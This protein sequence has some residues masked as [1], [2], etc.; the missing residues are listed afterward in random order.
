MIPSIVAH[1]LRDCVSDYL[2]TTFRGTS[3]GFDT[4]MERFIAQ[5]DNVGRGPYVSVGLPFRSGA[6]G[7]N[8]FP[9]IP[10][11]FSPHLHQE[12][13]FN[14][15]SPP[16]YQSTIVATGTG[17]GKTECFLLPLLEHCRQEAGKQGIKAIL[18]YPMNALA[19]DQAKRIAQLIDRT[20]SLKGRVTAGLYI[21]GE[22]DRP[23]A[24][25]SPEQVITDKSILRRSPPDI[26]L[27]NYKMLDY[28]LIQPETQGLWAFNQPETFRYLV[29]DEFHTFDG[30]QGT[31]LA[32]LVR[33]LKYRLQTPKQH[34]ACVG[35]SATL[36]GRESQTQMLAYAGQI[37]Q[38]SFDDLA[39][40]QEDR[41]SAAEFL[42]DAL[43]NVLPLPAP[44]SP[45]LPSEGMG[46]RA[47]LRQQAH[48]W[49]DGEEPAIELECADDAPL[50]EEW[51]IELGEKIATLPIVQILLKTVGEK[52]YS[53]TELLTDVL[54]KR[55]A[56][57][58]KD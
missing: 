16:Y 37:F 47:Y 29:V 26:L 13:A 55:L 15:L 25:M 5:S 52:T 24:M 57:P 31:D 17:S 46:V 34:L 9:E 3:P 12:R 7:A 32:C 51:C 11:Q 40:V 58:S 41:L 6:K 8:Y 10:L 50:S 19:T 45:L 22:E 39:I 27:T 20:P 28:L 18:L 30:A 4:L 33:R 23:T 44:N 21:G 53:Y 36:G 38:E 42:T 48:L 35:T 54:Q 49:L 56:L 2:L 1:Q 14:R 43:L